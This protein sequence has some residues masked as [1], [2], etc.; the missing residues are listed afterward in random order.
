[1]H[2]YTRHIPVAIT[3]G[4]L[5]VQHEYLKAQP[6]AITAEVVMQ[7]IEESVPSEKT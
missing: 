2:G 5:S 6:S 4:I 1:M 7:I 3:R